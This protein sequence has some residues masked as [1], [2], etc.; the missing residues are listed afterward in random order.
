MTTM[1]V[2]IRSVSALQKHEVDVTEGWSSSSTVCGHASKKALSYKLWVFLGG[3][4]VISEL[5]KV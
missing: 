2:K 3:G 1:I 4:D 5:W